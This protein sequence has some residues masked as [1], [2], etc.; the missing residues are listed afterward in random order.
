VGTVKSQ[1]SDALGKM[2]E[3]LG[4]DHAV[5]LPNDVGVTQ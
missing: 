3:R 1:V 4:A 5:L 2:R